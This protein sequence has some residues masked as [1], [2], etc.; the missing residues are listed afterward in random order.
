MSHFYP[1]PLKS[2]ADA[3]SI[4]EMSAGWGSDIMQDE[5]SFLVLDGA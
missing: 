3:D 1:C 2:E 4:P 5:P